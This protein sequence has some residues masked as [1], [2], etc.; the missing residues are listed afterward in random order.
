MAKCFRKECRHGQRNKMHGLSI[1]Y[2]GISKCT[3]TRALSKH[4]WTPAGLCKSC[5]YIINRY[6]PGPD[7]TPCSSSSI[8]QAWSCK[9]HC[10]AWLWGSCLSSSCAR[11]SSPSPFLH[12]HRKW[13]GSKRGPKQKGI[14]HWDPIQQSNLGYKQVGTSICPPNEKL[15]ISASI[16][17]LEKESWGSSLYLYLPKVFNF[18]I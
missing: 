8:S 13:D 6:R 17:E 12:C 2:T 5:M 1:L 9:Q 4:F 18:I 7:R 10:R 14:K 16:W 11:S 3:G 15:G